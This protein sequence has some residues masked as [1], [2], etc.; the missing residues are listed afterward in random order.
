MTAM[1]TPDGWR[2]ELR[3]VDGVDEFYV[4]RRGL[5]ASGCGSRF[6]DRGRY[7]TVAAVAQELGAAAFAALKE[8][9]N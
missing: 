9:R 5:A 8:E 2:V 7:H 3:Q 6:K 4:S 1:V